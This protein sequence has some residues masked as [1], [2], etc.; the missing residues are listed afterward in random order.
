MSKRT[1]ARRQRRQKWAYR[2]Q[3]RRTQD[4]FHE[5]LLVRL[6]ISIEMKLNVIRSRH[7]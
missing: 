4:C 2:P 6:W 3:I 1:R 7:W 5:S